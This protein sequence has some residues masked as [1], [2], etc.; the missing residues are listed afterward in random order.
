MSGDA[1]AEPAKND[2]LV[3]EITRQQVLG[4]VGIFLLII[5]LTI[6]GVTQAENMTAFPFYSD[7]EGSNIANGWVFMRDFSLSPYTYAYEEA[8][9]GT[10]VIG[11]WGAINSGFNN[12]GFVINS[13][14]VLMFGLHLLSVMFVFGIAKKL[15]DSDIAAVVAAL[16][17]AF[18]PLVTS[19]QRRVLVDNIMMMLVLLAFYLVIGGQRS[20]YNYIFSG[21]IFGAAVMVKTSAVFFYPAF[22]F[23]LRLQAHK[24]HKR[25]ALNLFVV[26]SILMMSL[27]PLY[28]QMREELFPQGWLL[29]GDFPHVS[30]IERLLDRGP[31]TDTFLNIGNGLTSSFNEWTT[32]NNFTADPVLILFGIGSMI[33]MG[34]LSRDAR[35]TRPLVAMVL[36]YFVGMLLMGNIVVSDAI[37]LLPFFAVAISMVVF[38]IARFV[39]GDSIF[40]KVLGAATL[41]LLLYPFWIFYSNRLELYTLD[42][43]SGQIEAVEW[44][45]ENVPEDEVVI[46][47]NYAYVALAEAR[48]SN[49]VHDYFRV[50]TD[51]DIKF[52]TFNDD[53]CNID[54]LLTSPQI[55]S[56]ID[57]FGLDLMRR[58]RDNAE[59][60]LEF[61]NEGWPIQVWQVSKADCDVEL[62]Q[63]EEDT[64]NPDDELRDQ[65]GG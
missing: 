43:V 39:A 19:I 34:I 48:G 60:V 61:E 58:A 53:H 36:C 1:H 49:L 52:V 10:F 27:Y 65:L 26:L 8:P 18:S 11:A 64:T 23:T 6:A 7:T 54:W 51:P 56:D 13:G 22:I 55:L 21:L 40:R 30:L 47:D 57:V 44:I 35:N 3:G 25:F 14:R 46:T 12:Y 63:E 41:V 4:R 20:L 62:P 50:D 24:H 17:F 32:L 37:A 28:A 16:L 29:G 42:Q 38:V 2:Q 5:V 59:A 9:F 15:T 31:E 45:L 33:V